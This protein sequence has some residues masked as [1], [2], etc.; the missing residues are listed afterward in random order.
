MP[1]PISYLLNLAAASDAG[2][3]ADHVRGVLIGIAPIVGTARVAS[4]TA[5]IVE[6]LADAV[7]LAELAEQDEQ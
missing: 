5:N 6:A 3:T 7:D 1:P 2:L 4:A